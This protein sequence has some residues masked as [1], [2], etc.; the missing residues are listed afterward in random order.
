VGLAAG[1]TTLMKAQRR[2]TDKNLETVANKEKGTDYNP[3]D[4]L[5]DNHISKVV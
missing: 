1:S 3:L 5:S 2:T 4:L